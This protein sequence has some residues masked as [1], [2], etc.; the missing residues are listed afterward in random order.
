MLLRYSVGLLTQLARSAKG[1]LKTTDVAS[2]KYLES[3]SP[4]HT[5]HKERKATCADLNLCICMC[6]LIF[7][8]ALKGS[9]RK[10]ACVTWY[11]MA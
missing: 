8:A 10:L 5:T 7:F 4:R 1:T 2:R 11:V 3:A 9:F 6:G